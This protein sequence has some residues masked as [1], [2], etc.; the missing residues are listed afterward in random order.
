MPSKLENV[1]KTQ[2]ERQPEKKPKIKKIN[3]IWKRCANY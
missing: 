1:S 3:L 2:T